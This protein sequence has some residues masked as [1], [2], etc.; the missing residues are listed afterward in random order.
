MSR[1][2]FAIGPTYVAENRLGTEPVRKFPPRLSFFS[3][4]ML[5]AV[6]LAAAAAAVILFA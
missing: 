2:S 5:A 4:T 6:V 1:F 3:W